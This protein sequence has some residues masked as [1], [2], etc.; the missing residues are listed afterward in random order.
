MPAELHHLTDGWLELESDPGLFTLLVE[1]FGCKGVQVEEIYDLQRTNLVDGQAYGFIFLFKWLEERRSRTRDRYKPTYSLSNGTNSSDSSSKNLPQPV[2]IEDAA[3]INTL[4]FAQQIIPNSCATHALLSVLLNCSTV[5]L[6]PLLARIKE[7]TKDM[8]PEN[9]G[10]A[11]GNAPELAK[12][13]N[14]HASLQD[15]EPPANVEKISVGTTA[16]S[17]NQRNGI[18]ADSFHFVSYVPINGRL[19]ELDGLKR[20]PIDHG[21]IEAGQDWTEKFRKII[22]QRIAKEQNCQTSGDGMSHDIRYNLMAVVPD[23]RIAYMNKLSTL[24]SN[25]HIVLE[26]LEC[27]M[28]PTRLPGPLDY[29]SYSKY[30]TS[31]EYKEAPSLNVT[32]PGS[33][34][35]VTKPLTVETTVSETS[36]V[37]T[38]FTSNANLLATPLAILT[39]VSP[40]PSASSSTDSCSDASSAFNSPNPGTSKNAV[41]STNPAERCEKFFVCKV[42]PSADSS[43]FNK[44]GGLNEV[45]VNSQQ[46]PTKQ[47]PARLAQLTPK[48]KEK[49]EKITKSMN[50]VRDIVRL[51]KAL[52]EE[53]TAIESNLKEELEKRKKYRVDASRRTHNYDDFIT[54]FLLMLAEQGKLPDLLE[55][56]LSVSSNA[57]PQPSSVDESPESPSAFF[58]EL[59]LA[60]DDLS[61]EDTVSPPKRGNKGSGI[62]EFMNKMASEPSISVQPPAKAPVTTSAPVNKSRRVAS[63]PM[64]GRKRKRK[65]LSPAAARLRI[66]RS[67]LKQ[68]NK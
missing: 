42:A 57:L 43:N 14:S 16:R 47:L 25:R 40:A 68:L 59:Q 67:R 15:T 3:V 41:I 48:T 21:P 36:C 45:K 54:T 24:K 35:P 2:Y 7:H 30:P 23:R 29:H 13:H 8:N 60:Y 11:I 10:Y 22:T 33:L 26:A 58:A 51:L 64:V 55:R 62:A 37:N 66:K 52:D 46:S 5:E 19:Y 28:R 20:C 44:Y 65:K 27:M 38:R 32:S 1:D 63:T 17:M 6:G 9:K 50:G 34:D 4:F 49:A 56:S 39:S 31:M 61:T 53:I 18:T 12:V